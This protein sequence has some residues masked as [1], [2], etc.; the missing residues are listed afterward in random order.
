[1]S[2]Y[3]YETSDADDV[4]NID[5]EMLD[6]FNDFNAEYANYVRCNYN[7]KN[8][9]NPNISQLLDLNGNVL[10]CTVNQLN[11][12]NVLKK[13]NE[14]NDNIL[15]LNQTLSSMPPQGNTVPEVLDV[16]TLQSTQ[17]TLQ[18]KQ[19][20]LVKLRSQIDSDLNELNEYENSISLSKRKVLDSNI[21]ATLLWTTAATILVLLVFKNM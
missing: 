17:T 11:G 13:Y 15:K 7:N 6:Q 21:Y 9:N 19:T 20:D 8:E 10:Q 5:N 3:N 1:M 18:T 12:Q 4:Y 14:L 16:Q 2:V